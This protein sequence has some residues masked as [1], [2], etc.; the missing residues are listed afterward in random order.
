[1]A[2]FNTSVLGAIGN[3]PIVEL[4]RYGSEVSPLLLAKLEFTNP[5]GSMKDRAALGMIEWA[6]RELSPG[7]EIIISTSGNLGI[8]MAMT[9]AVK[10]YQLICLVDPKL[11]PSTERSLELLGAELV[12]VDERDQTGGYHLTRLKRLEMLQ[13]ERPD[14]IYLDQYDSP[15]AIEAHRSST[16]REI[17]EQMD[18]RLDAMIMVAGTGGSSMGVARWL[19]EHSPATRIW[20]VDE[21]GSL[22]LPC[23]GAPE[24]RCFNRVWP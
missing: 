20:L 14:A 13:A 5:G 9:C 12:K 24:P 18:G 2:G 19:R 8:G 10:G 15:A 6:E 7:A 16:G 4:N 23:S 22:A 1:M 11:N 17:L 3:T 21:V